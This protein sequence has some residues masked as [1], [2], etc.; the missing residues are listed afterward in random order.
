[1]LDRTKPF[2]LFA[3]CVPVRGARR[4]SICDLQRGKLHLIP[5]GLYEIVTEHRDRT[6]PE[7]EA[8]YGPECSET[9]QEYFTFLLG[10][11][12]GFWCDDPEAFPDLDLSWDRPERVTNAIIDCGAGSAHDWESLFGQL[13]ELGCKALQLR[14]FVPIALAEL[15]AVLGLLHGT[16]ARSVELLLPWSGEWTREEL[17]AT[18]FPHQRVSGVVVHSAPMDGVDEGRPG[19]AV[20]R[21]RDEVMDSHAHCGQVHPAYFA[22][23]LG[24]FTEATGFNSCLN[25][26]LSVD[27][28]GEIRNC[29]SMPRTFGNA[30]GTPLA[31]ALAAPGFR[32]PW[33][34]TKD[35]VETCRDCEFRYVCTDCR[36]FTRESAE[37]HAKP[38]RCTYD[39]YAAK[40]DASSSAA[41]A[42][43][44]TG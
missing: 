6:V 41:A 24:A 35:Q 10:N 13:D 22:V 29:P 8:M 31:A 38:S 14:F 30:A 44:A 4:S 42:L 11:D 1:M 40:W 19:D 5:N 32:D 17:R 37:R 26:K 2:R 27:E 7:L 15:D 28:R 43:A 3:G 34:V 20:I 21:Y 33:S 9:L 12:L 36:A 39:P 18:V 25:R 23:T 16:R